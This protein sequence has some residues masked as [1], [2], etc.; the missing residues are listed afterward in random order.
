MRLQQSQLSLQQ[1]SSL[2]VM[3]FLNEVI[4]QY[5][6]A[7][8]FASGRPG[9]GFFEIERVSEHV[10]KYVQYRAAQLEVSEKEVYQKLGQ[11]GP[12]QGIIGDVLAKHLDVQEGISVQP[13]HILVTD[14][15]QEGMA[16]FLMTLFDPAK[17]V[18]LVTDP[19][20]IGIVGM[21]SVLNIEICAVEMDDEGPSIEHLDSLVTDI[22]ERRKRARGLYVVPEFSNPLGISFSQNRR[23]QLLASCLSHELLILE[24][25]PYGTF[26]YSDS[27]RHCLKSMDTEGGV[28]YLG[29]FAK[30]LC[31]SLRVGYMV[32]DQQVFGEGRSKP[33]MESFVKVKSFNTL[34]T[35]HLNQATVA[36]VL[37]NEEYSLNRFITPAKL[38]YQSNRDEM[39]RC[40]DRHFSELKNAYKVSWNSPDGGFF[41]V[42][43]LPVEFTQ[44][45]CAE[46]ADKFK[47]IC[48]PLAFFSESELFK[49]QIRLSF[50][51][52]TKDDI[53]PAIKSLAQYI[54]LLILRSQRNA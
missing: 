30:S 51:Y 9:E 47:V 43:D 44:E 45:Q 13:E 2:N 23:L 28:I 33:L 12:T 17:D 32:I 5:P 1:N 10:A 49:K 42:I 20:Y 19:A 7:I 40:L 39:L 8:S 54:Q 29:T 41:M 21:A 35:S 26:R 15:A 38:H 37:L 25:N 27:A 6:D 4:E 16:L 31:P 22:R 11:Y 14:G 50:S 52:V 34:N 48:V 46:C 36:G 53:E 3:N 18:L 24:D